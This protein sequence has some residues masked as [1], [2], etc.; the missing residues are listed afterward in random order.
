MATR[1]EGRDNGRTAWCYQNPVGVECGRCGRRGLVSLEA[2]G[3][4]SGDMRPLIDRRFKCTVCSSSFVG[5]FLFASA[6]EP[7]EWAAQGGRAGARQIVG[8]TSGGTETPEA[9]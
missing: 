5:L 7:A 9:R 2:I 1:V 6:V 4:G 3:A 8:G